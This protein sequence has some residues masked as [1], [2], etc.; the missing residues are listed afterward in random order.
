MVFSGDGIGDRSSWYI[1][2]VRHGVPQKQ[3][4]HPTSCIHYKRVGRGWASV[5]GRRYYLL[6]GPRIIITSFYFFLDKDE[7]LGRLRALIPF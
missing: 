2:M 7:W 6:L 4:Q 1:A 3:Y 5:T